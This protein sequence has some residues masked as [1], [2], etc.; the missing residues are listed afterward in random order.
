MVINSPMS[1]GAGGLTMDGS[2]TLTLTASNSY[3][4]PTTVNA[5]VVN[6][7]NSNALGASGATVAGGAALQ[8][9]G[10]LTVA[11][12]L[13]LNGMG[14]ANDGALRNVSGNNTYAG[15]ITLGSA[16]RINSDS[17][18]LTLSGVVNPAGGLTIGGSGNTT[19]T[20]TTYGES[21]TKDGS[22]TLAFANTLV[23][24]NSSSGTFTLSAGAVTAPNETISNGPTGAVV[25][26]G[27]LNSISGNLT[28]GMS[29]TGTYT[30]NGGTN[31]VAGAEII[32]S[33]PG[34][35]YYTLT[36]GSNSVGALTFGSGNSS[37]GGTYNLNGGMLTVGSG[38]ITKGAGTGVTATF[39]LAG[40]TLQAGTGFSS[41]IGLATSGASTVDTQANSV[42]LSGLI[43]GS[44]SLSKIG[45]GTLILSGANTYGGATTI[46]QGTLQLG[47]GSANNG[48]VSGNIADNATLAFAN[49]NPQTYSGVI[50]GNGTLVKSGGGASTLSGANSYG[51]TTVNAGQLIVGNNLTNS[52]ALNVNSG[53]ISQ[54][55]YV[56]SAASQI[57]GNAG[58]GYYL[59]SGGTNTVS[60]ALTLCAGTSTANTGWTGTYTLSGG[61]N[62]VNSLVFGSSNPYET[63]TG[64]YNLN[65]GTLAVGTG[66]IVANN[67]SE[68]YPPS[69]TFNLG[70]GTLRA[71]GNFTINSSPFFSM[72]LTANGSAIDTQGNTVTISAPISGAY[73]LTK[74][75]SGT[76][77]LSVANTY[78]GGTTLSAGQLNINNNSALGAGPFS[79]GS[80]AIIDNTSVAAVTLSVPTGGALSASGGSLTFGGTSNDLTLS[81]LSMGSG[82]SPT[83]NVAGTA[84]RLILGPIPNSGGQS[85]TKQGP[86]TLVMSGDTPGQLPRTITISAGTLQLGNGGAS[87]TFGSNAAVVDNAA[88]TFN[89][90]SA[91]IGNLISG[92]G[93]VAQNG[94]GSTITFTGANSYKG[95]TTVNYGVLNIQNATALGTTNAGTTVAGGAAL[96]IQGGITTAAEALT[97]NGTGVANDGAL[98]N[99]SGNNTYAGAI[100]LGSARGSIP[101]AAR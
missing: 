4:G 38:G 56:V 15:N 93:T 61:L 10:G 73:A 51:A 79:P 19:I 24:G 96:Q 45:S 23:V 92:T 74:T 39:N 2:G 25:Q 1:L 58:N 91:T 86:G 21:M 83:I 17:G 65:G 26:S 40:G 42:T 99:V 12:A 66:S 55:G 5:G 3:T 7:Q 18:T 95:A 67:A 88:L 77:T 8:V 64:T 72:A 30:Q 49:P 34:S 54:S 22:G 29:G 82:A 80:G 57:I 53:T 44:G 6:I 59:Q 70:G 48:S 32:G 37:S 98:R 41:S 52:G 28:V 60:G 16:A 90:A 50:S 69:W 68:G 76:L 27:G 100:T 31:N 101:T 97:L 47:D 43:S 94:S 89:R 36:S 9:Q 81:N 35:S 84:G 62:G 85:L 87:G 75:G 20:G 71:T 33:N 14:V 13:T 78:S 46:S 63:G 11:N